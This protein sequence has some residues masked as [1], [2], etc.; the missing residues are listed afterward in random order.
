MCTGSQ[1]TRDRK[2]KVQWVSSWK[3]EDMTQWIKVSCYR[4]LE[5]NLQR[6]RGQV[7]GQ[8]I[9]HATASGRLHQTE[10]C[11]QIVQILYISK[12]KCLWCK[13]TYINVGYNTGC[14]SRLCFQIWRKKK[15][16]KGAVSRDFRPLFFF[17][18]QTHLGP[19]KQVKMV[20]LKN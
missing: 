19:D 1:R 11:T 15:P 8:V 4:E 18:N 10:G 3:T 12:W 14:C 5:G 9:V 17:I 2:D 7:R 20:F 6:V 13:C 16:F